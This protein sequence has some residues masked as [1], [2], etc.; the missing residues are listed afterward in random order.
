[1]THSLPRRVTRYAKALCVEQFKPFCLV[2][3]A[4]GRLQSWHPDGAAYGFTDLTPGIDLRPRLTFLEGMP[5]DDPGPHVIHFLQITD[6]HSVDAHILPSNDGCCILFMDVTEEWHHRKKIQQKA[7]ELEIARHRQQRLIEQLEQARAEL[8]V[9]RHQAEEANTLKGRFIASFSHELRTPLTAILGFTRLLKDKPRSA[10]TNTH[11]NAIQRA[12]N[13]LL[14]FINNLLDEASLEAGQFDLHPAPSCPQKLFD[15]LIEMF[16]PLA[17]EKGLQ[18]QPHPERL[19]GNVSL[20]ETRFRQCMINLLGNAVKFT[21]TGYVR[22]V[23][24]WR[25]ERLYFSIE[26]TGPGIPAQAHARIFLAFHREQ[27]GQNPHISGAGLGL[28]IC[29]MLIERM[30]GSLK[31]SSRPGAGSRFHGFVDAPLLAQPEAS[32]GQPGQTPRQPATILVAEDDENLRELAQLQLGS[33]GYQVIFAHDGEEAVTRT[34]D[35]HPDLVI[36]DQHMPGLDGLSATR[37]LRAM[38]HHGPII[39]VT[40]SSSTADHSIAIE[41]GSD[42]FVPKRPDP[43][44]LL[45]TI[46]QLLHKTRT[47]S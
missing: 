43:G 47:S 14:S 27:T 34:L 31:L 28:P 37:R 45:A 8:E 10:E 21:P 17:N 42:A 40:A 25:D 36:M 46:E 24:E 30:G 29:K 5:L 12:S 18:L 16:T 4:R 6:D 39:A 3:D 35:D 32:A 9:R 7:N 13:H 38:A 19:P 44:P 20:D 2:L 11:L 15:E 33:A 41:A 26:D 1:M 23:M 22:F